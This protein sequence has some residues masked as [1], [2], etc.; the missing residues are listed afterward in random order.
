MPNY[1]NTDDAVV[2]QIRAVPDV[3]GRARDLLHRGCPQGSS[4]AASFK[5]IPGAHPRLRFF[6]APC[7]RSMVPLGLLAITSPDSRHPRRGH[8]CHFR[9]LSLPGSYRTW[10]ARLLG[11]VVSST[12]PDHACHTEQ[13]LNTP[14]YLRANRQVAEYPRI[15]GVGVGRFC[16]P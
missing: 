1:R 11:G 5:C 8:H 10:L 15:R 7:S 9:R 16:V 6:A 3:S 13:P 12:D 14:E 4:I 2:S